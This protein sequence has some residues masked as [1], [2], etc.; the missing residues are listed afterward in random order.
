LY[1]YELTEF[2]ISLWIGALATSLKRM[3]VVPSS[4]A[5]EMFLNDRHAFPFSEVAQLGVFVFLRRVLKD[6]SGVNK[7]YKEMGW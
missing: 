4:T 7:P 3:D 6:S 2:D 1:N 5:P